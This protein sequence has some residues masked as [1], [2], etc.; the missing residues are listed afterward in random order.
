MINVLYHPL[1]DFVVMVVLGYGRLCLI[2]HVVLPF[3]ESKF[4]HF[5]NNQIW[6][7]GFQRIYKNEVLSDGVFLN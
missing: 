2:A 4:F 5:T 6:P 3:E 7:I 1:V